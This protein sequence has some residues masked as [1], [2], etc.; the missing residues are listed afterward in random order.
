MDQARSRR[1]LQARRAHAG[2][3]VT[4]E[5]KSS[6]AQTPSG[7]SG[8]E[9]GAQSVSQLELDDN[10]QAEQSPDANDTLEQLRQ[11]EKQAKQQAGHRPNK[12][13]MNYK[14]AKELVTTKL[15]S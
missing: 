1:H 11:A 14:A 6:V 4:K 2:R 7:A 12:T 8:A 9:G 5:D 15:G 3:A 10:R 13:L